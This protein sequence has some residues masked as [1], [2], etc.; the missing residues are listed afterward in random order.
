MLCFVSVLLMREMNSASGRL[1]SL[2]N[3]FTVL[4]QP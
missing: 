2:L 4:L 3:L 1:Y